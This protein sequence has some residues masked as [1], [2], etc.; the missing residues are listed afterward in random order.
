MINRQTCEHEAAHA[1]LCRHFGVRVSEI[2]VDHPRQGV[3]GYCRFY[4]D[5]W[6]GPERWGGRALENAA[7]TLA[8]AVWFTWGPSRRESADGFDMDFAAFASLARDSGLTDGAARLDWESRARRL[9]RAVLD[10]RRADVLRIAGLL[11]RHGTWTENGGWEPPPGRRRPAPSGDG[12]RTFDRVA[13]L[14]RQQRPVA[15]YGLDAPEYSLED[16]APRLFVA[17]QRGQISGPEADRLWRAAGGPPN[18]VRSLR[19]RGAA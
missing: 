2:R 18:T 8:P 17:V 19:G 15:S 14:I 12:M 9:A 13:G 7:M 3:A 11:E 6:L 1:V 5:D 4:G 16:L 10:E